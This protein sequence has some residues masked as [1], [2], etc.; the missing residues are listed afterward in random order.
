MDTRNKPWK[1]ADDLGGVP[2]RS[3]MIRLALARVSS[4]AATTVMVLD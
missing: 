1:G 3:H 2:L 4:T